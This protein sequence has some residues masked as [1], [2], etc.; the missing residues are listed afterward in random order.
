[1]WRAFS[2]SNEERLRRELYVDCSI[3]ITATLH[4]RG[5]EHTHLDPGRTR[6]RSYS[7]R[8]FSDH[9]HSCGE[10]HLEL[11]RSRPT[12]DG[13][14]CRYYY[15]AESYNNRRQH[16]AHRVAIAVWN[17]GCESVSPAQPHPPPRD[18]PGYAGV[19]YPA[20]AIARGDRA[21]PPPFV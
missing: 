10:H 12:R 19:S 3:S 18:C 4:F 2:L 21:P 13:R 20:P 1:M 7:N 8:Y 9:R 14:P 17:R 16:R 5:D 11:Q 6:D 15:G